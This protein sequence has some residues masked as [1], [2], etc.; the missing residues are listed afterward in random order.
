MVNI[1]EFTVRPRLGNK[2]VDLPFGG[3]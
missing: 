3:V 1:H 2:I